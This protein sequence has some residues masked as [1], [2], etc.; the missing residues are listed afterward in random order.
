MQ[1]ILGFSFPESSFANAAALAD[2]LQHGCDLL[3]RQSRP[4]EDGAFPFRETRLTGTTTKHASGLVRSIM[5]A[6]R[7]VSGPSLAMVRTLRILAAKAGKIVHDR[8]S[9]T[10]LPENKPLTTR[11]SLY[12]N[13]HSPCNIS[14]TQGKIVA[15]PQ[16]CATLTVVSFR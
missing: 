13:T 9:M 11:R 4:K 1:W 7:Q 10:Q 5:V 3:L 6:H 2:V 16:I 14:R 15:S 12:H 8:S